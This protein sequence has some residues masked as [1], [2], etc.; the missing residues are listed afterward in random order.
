MEEDDLN[1]SY[2]DEEFGVGNSTFNSVILNESLDSSFEVDNA[3]L[4]TSTPT[5]AKKGRNTFKEPKAPP[6]AFFK[7]CGLCNK[8]LKREQ[9]YKQ[10]M[11]THKWK[12]SLFIIINDNSSQTAVLCTCLFFSLQNVLS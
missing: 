6:A 2:G 7:K 3:G 11:K 5:K 12:G 10:H 1:F 9:G 4:T 8:Y